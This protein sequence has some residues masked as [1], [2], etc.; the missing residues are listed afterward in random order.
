MWSDPDRSYGPPLPRKLKQSV[1]RAH[2]GVCH[3][4]GLPGGDE[5]DH[6][7]NRRAGGTDDPSNLAPIHKKPCHV[8]KT[9]QEAASARSARKHRK[10]PEHPGRSRQ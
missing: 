4:C 1:L 3:W 2:K 6:V 7:L 8:A 9:Q 5:V 10:P